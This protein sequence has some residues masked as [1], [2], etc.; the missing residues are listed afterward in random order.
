MN[1]F[2]CF[3]ILILMASLSRGRR[4]SNRLITRLLG[5]SSRIVTLPVIASGNDAAKFHALVN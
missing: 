5:F 1:L 3:N 2:V 4:K